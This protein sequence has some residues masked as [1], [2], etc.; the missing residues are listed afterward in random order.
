[1]ITIEQVSELWCPVYLMLGFIMGYTFSLADLT[2]KA[3]KCNQ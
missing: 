3:R 2:D 1:M